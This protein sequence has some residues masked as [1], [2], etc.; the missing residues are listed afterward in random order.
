MEKA[1]Q[2]YGEKKTI[3]T[4]N[5]IIS[6]AQ[7]FPILH[8]AL[9]ETPKLDTLFTTWFPWASNL[10]D[11]NNRT[12]IQAILAA[13][14]KVVTENAHVFASM[15]DDQI[16]EKD[17]VTTLYPFPA[18]ASGEAGDLE[19]TFYLLRRQPGVLDRSET[20]SVE[21]VTDK[22]GKKKRKR[23]ESSN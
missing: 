16:C 20:R 23:G 11:H 13:G 7:Q 21:Q 8:H 18:V 6:P 19:K 22:L 10:R 4:I 17:P 3:T 12:L 15:S 9:V 1:I 14:A 5:E 2:K